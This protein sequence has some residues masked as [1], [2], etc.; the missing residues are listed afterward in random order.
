MNHHKSLTMRKLK[1]QVQMTADGYIA[2]PTGEMDWMNFN[3]GE[4]IMQY[5][6]GITE[7]ESLRLWGG[8]NEKFAHFSS[9]NNK[10]K[11]F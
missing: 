3:W 9:E 6:A 1:L 8:G 7:R 4:D 5:V 11:V 10:Q 2:G